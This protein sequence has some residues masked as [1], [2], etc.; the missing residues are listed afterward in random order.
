MHREHYHRRAGRNRGDLP[1]SIESV[2]HRHLK[3]QDYQIRLQFS[4]FL[5]SDFAVLCL[6][7]YLPATLL[8]N[9]RAE[10]M[11]DDCAVVD[12]QNGIGQ[13]VT[14]GLESANPLP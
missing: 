11:T 4:D 6:A 13:T 8:L 7:A 14:Y 10:R 3:I 1:G 9:A 2:H 12:D 5:N